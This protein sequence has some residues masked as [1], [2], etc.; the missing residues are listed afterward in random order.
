MSKNLLSLF[1]GG[2]L[3]CCL[4]S[5]FTPR[6]VIRVEPDDSEVVF[7]SHG[8][9]IA[10]QQENG[11]WC[12]AAFSHANPDFL[13]F[14]IEVI[15]QGESD[16]L[17]T[18]E[19]MD[20]IAMPNNF[21]LPAVDPERVLLSMEVDAS[22]REA[23][24]KNVAVA[25]GVVVAAAVVAAAVSD[26]GNDNDNND[27]VDDY[28]VADAIVDVAVP[29]LYLSATF[30][31]EPPL[32]TPVNALPP[33]EEVIFWSDYALRRTTLRPDESIRGLVAFPRYDDTNE[34]HLDVPIDELSFQFQFHQRVIQ[35]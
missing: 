18:P 11:I 13:V 1:V 2:C 6:T 26:D 7:W 34:F 9:A 23:N 15:N 10:E 4:S 21:R 19:D 33:A 27:V 29:A 12:R 5:C 35:P 31:S 24:A 30:A 22:R 25:T 3:V 8:Q 17:V 20:L 14:D 32:S 16:L 28:D